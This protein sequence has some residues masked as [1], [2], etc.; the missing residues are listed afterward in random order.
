MNKYL[1]CS[2]ALFAVLPSIACAQGASSTSTTTTTMT[3]PAPALSPNAFE[4]TPSPES[5][6]LDYRL[7]Y[8]N[9]FN[10]V[11][12]DDATTQH[13]S[14]RQ[15][16]QIYKLAKEAHVEF[17]EIFGF[18]RD[19]YTFATLAPMYGVD[20]STLKDVTREQDEID[21]YESA[22][23]GTGIG[24]LTR[25]GRVESSIDSVKRAATH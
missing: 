21:G 7:L 14:D 13:L 16:A 20:A 9:T 24:S 10:K 2:A 15:I 4:V 12:L 11:D 19:G 18:V 17:R 22:Y 6:R 5:E 23:A 3:A 8:N 25:P 1:L